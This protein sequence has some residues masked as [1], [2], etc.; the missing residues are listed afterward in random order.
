MLQRAHAACFSSISKA[1]VPILF[2]LIKLSAFVDVLSCV[3]VF[4]RQSSLLRSCHSGLATICGSNKLF[5]H[6]FGFKGVG[7]KHVYE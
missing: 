4:D 7:P 2:C 6:R 1:L 5:G 3:E